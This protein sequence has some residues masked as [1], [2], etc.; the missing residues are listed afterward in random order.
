MT[1]GVRYC[2]AFKTDELNVGACQ[3]GCWVFTEH[4][5]GS[6]VWSTVWR[7]KVQRCKLLGHGPFISGQNIM[8]YRSGKIDALE[9]LEI[10]LIQSSATHRAT[11]KRLVCHTS[12][13]G[14]ATFLISGRRRPPGPNT[15]P[16]T[17]VKTHRRRFRRLNLNDNQF[18]SGNHALLNGHQW[19]WQNVAIRPHVRNVSKQFVRARKIGAGA[20]II[21]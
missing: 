4:E 6:H 8:C 14:Q 21:S 3:P 11:I 7:E 12:F 9:E 5:D 1:N 20:V 16:D 10:K 17:T 2:N 15:N 19:E 18:A 13:L